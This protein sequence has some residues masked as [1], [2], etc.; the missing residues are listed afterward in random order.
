MKLRWV[1]GGFVDLPKYK[2]VEIVYLDVVSVVSFTAHSFDLCLTGF[3]C[4][5]RFRFKCEMLSHFPKNFGQKAL[6]TSESKACVL[7]VAVI[8]G[9]SGTVIFR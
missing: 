3:R 6:A 5:S 8:D 9:D 1:D 4:P 2:F 7:I